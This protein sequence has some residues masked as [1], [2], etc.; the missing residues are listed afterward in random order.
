LTHLQILFSSEYFT[1]KYYNE[2]CLESYNDKFKENLLRPGIIDARAQQLRYTA[3]EILMWLGG[4][5][6]FTENSSLLSS[7]YLQMIADV[8]EVKATSFH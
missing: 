2:K 8:D 6:N 5:C 7:N 3:L 4:K 1:V